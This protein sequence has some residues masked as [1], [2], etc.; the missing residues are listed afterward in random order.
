[1]ADWHRLSLLW[2]D[3]TPGPAQCECLNE[4]L[5]RL[6]YD[7]P[8]VT[9]HGIQGARYR[10]PLLTLQEVLDFCD[11]RGYPCRGKLTR[12]GDEEELYVFDIHDVEGWTSSTTTFHEKFGG[13]MERFAPRRTRFERI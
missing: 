10:S 2:V 5:Y 1:M 3:C 12:M 8:K 6:D 7:C 13:V 9:P 4:D 11:C